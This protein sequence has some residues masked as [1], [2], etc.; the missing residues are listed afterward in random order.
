MQILKISQ[1]FLKSSPELVQSTMD[2]SR[3]AHENTAVL[4]EMFRHLHT[5]KGNAR[6]LILIQF[7]V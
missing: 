2:L 6:P 4:G 7:L 5:L 1:L 3:V